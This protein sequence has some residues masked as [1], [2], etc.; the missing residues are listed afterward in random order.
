MMYPK[1]FSASATTGRMIYRGVVIEAQLRLEVRP[2]FPYDDNGAPQHKQEACWTRWYSKDGIATQSLRAALSWIDYE[3]S[4]VPAESDRLKALPV[5]TRVGDFLKTDF[6]GE[7]ES[8]GNWFVNLWKGTVT[9][10]AS[11]AADRCNY[12]DRWR[13]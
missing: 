12:F 9:H 3:Q 1:Y 6:Q 8:P 11:L 2:P 5:G 13:K 10:Y 7:H 4:G